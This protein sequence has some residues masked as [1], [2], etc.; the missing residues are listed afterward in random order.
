MDTHFFPQ[1]V[2]A[3]EPPTIST[4]FQTAKHLHIFI[5]L[6]FAL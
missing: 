4:Y 2:L 5:A 3:I 6:R 1:V